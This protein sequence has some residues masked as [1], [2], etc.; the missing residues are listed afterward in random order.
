MIVVRHFLRISSISLL[1]PHS[2]VQTDNKYL[3]TSDD[4]CYEIWLQGENA[5]LNP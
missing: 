4:D 3:V 2:R 1:L 5:T